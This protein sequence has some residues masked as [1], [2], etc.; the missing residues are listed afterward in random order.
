MTTISPAN[1]D[2]KTL[3][4][5]AAT[6][7]LLT[8]I[9]I[10][11][12]I[13]I[14]PDAEKLGQPQSAIPPVDPV[15]GQQ[16]VIEKDS[17]P[18][19]ALVA[20]TGQ[21][22]IEDPKTP[23]LVD[24]EELI[25]AFLEHEVI[26]SVVKMNID[27]DTKNTLA[28]ARI[29]DVLILD[30]FLDSTNQ[31]SSKTRDLI[32]SVLKTDESL[33]GRLRLICVYT[34]MPRIDELAVLLLKDILDVSAL[35]GF[36]ILPDEPT[37]IQSR[38]AKIVFANK[39]SVGDSEKSM[40]L[41]Q[42]PDFVADHFSDLAQGLL[43]ATVVGAVAAIRKTTH[44][45]IAT[46]HPDLDGA[47]AAH[48]LMIPNR[49]DAKPFLLDLILDELRNNI[50]DSDNVELLNTSQAFHTWMDQKATINPQSFGL[51]T[52]ASVREVLRYI[53]NFVPAQLSDY[54]TALAQAVTAQNF[55]GERMTKSQFMSGFDEFP[56]VFYSTSESCRAHTNKF[57]EIVVLARSTGLRTSLLQKWI[58]RLNLG[59]I[60]RPL[61]SDV[62]AQLGLDADDVL[63]CIQPSCQ[64]L[65]IDQEGR[66]FPFL[67]ATPPVKMKFNYI[68]NG[69]QFQVDPHL[70]N[71]K[72]L[73]FTPS[74]N[75]NGCILA[76]KKESIWIFL[77]EEREFEWLADIRP[78]FAQR[79][80]AGLSA[81]TAAVGTD[82]FEWLRRKEKGGW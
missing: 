34:G 75:S 56:Q 31:N 36:T 57:S 18:Q 43:P 24:A 62:K 60:V 25:D 53:E 52:E 28:A 2:F 66:A 42:L 16:F 50:L 65:R 1:P 46:F 22:S 49:E 64:C 32:C 78:L 80:S 69:S 76:T 17:N 55:A 48:R 20:I 5:K 33:G 40:G 29:A 72:M 38:N 4:R 26:C 39:L 13:Q 73:K 35:Q 12:E 51:P 10:D 19:L 68:W 74:E 47:F 9:F 8:A 14:I 82:Q 3:C 21:P 63:I 15:T 61:S 23:N 44:H 70:F 30:W 71:L 11:D 27:S 54:S 37:V 6:E 58:P 77:S 45:L 67:R 81:R 79:L 59:T 7:F 41:R